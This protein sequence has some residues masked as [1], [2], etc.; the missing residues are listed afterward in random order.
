M[1]NQRY[2]RTQ[3][4]W[5]I[6][7][8]TVLVAAIVLPI[9]AANV[10]GILPRAFMAV[11]LL[12]MIMFATLTVV[13]D[14]THLAFHFTLGLIRKRIALADIRHYRTVKFL[15]CSRMAYLLVPIVK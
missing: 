7:A 9:V 2:R 5:I 14:D 15:G 1:S 11:I 8:A 13:V 3:T 12:L 10:A 4:G 6:I